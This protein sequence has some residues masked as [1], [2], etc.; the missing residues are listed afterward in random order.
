[1]LK[2]VWKFFPVICDPPVFWQHHYFIEGSFSNFYKI[3]R[4][5]NII[6]DIWSVLVLVQLRQRT[7]FSAKKRT[8]IRRGVD[9]FIHSK[10]VV[11]MRK[12]DLYTKLCTLST[13]FDCV[14]LDI[15]YGNHRNNCFV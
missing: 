5:I 4:I 10:K 14:L 2:C 3:C 9:N 15:F 8:V 1:M 6:S 13:G 7:C 12:W 11:K